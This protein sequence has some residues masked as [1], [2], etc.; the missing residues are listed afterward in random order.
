LIRQAN[1]DYPLPMFNQ[2]LSL[3][4][5]ESPASTRPDQLQVAVA[6]LMVHAAAMDDTF[7]AAERRTIERL[8]GERF[9]LKPDAVKALLATAETRAAE[10][11]QLYPFTRLAVERLDEPGR[12]QLVEM[13]WEV[14]YADGV[15]DP[16]EDALLRRVAGLLYV[17]DFD[18]GEARKRVL[19]RMGLSKHN[20][21]AEAKRLDER[22]SDMGTRPKLIAGNW[23]MNGTRAEAKDF[24][25][26][27]RKLDPQ[28]RPGRQLLIC[29]P[30]TLIAG[31][32]PP[33][34]AL[35]V[36]IG[37]Q[38]CHPGVN[39]AFTGDV[40]AGMLRDAGASYVI[41]GHSER[42]AMHGETDQLVHVKALAARRHDLIPIICV[43]ETLAEREDGHAEA[44]VR[45]QVRD[46]VPDGIEGDVLVIAYEPVWAIGTGRTATLEDIATMHH[47]IREALSGKS[48][49]AECGLILYGGSVKPGNAAAILAID[50]VDGALIGGASLAAADFMAIADAV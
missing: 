4:S 21:A 46:S 13:L 34:A 9:K 50:G 18:R 49:D 38:N 43:G 27:L 28:P 42:R 29:P 2:I 1:P 37:G 31:M 8:L 12:V 23:K 47:V 11:S 33:L 16:D 40:S 25:E 3:L 30:A 17:S 26:K 32:A 7:D 41:I 39:G 36:A 22:D 6:A 14:A 48:D 19:R 20:D 5:G 35:N 45:K 15:L 24:V 10:S 44:V